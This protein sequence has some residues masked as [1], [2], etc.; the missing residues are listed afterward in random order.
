MYVLVVVSSEH[1]FVILQ[2]T[3]NPQPTS[4]CRHDRT[5]TKTDSETANLTLR[6]HSDLEESE[7]TSMILQLLFPLQLP[8]AFNP[9]DILH[10][11]KFQPNQ[12]APNYDS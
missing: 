9:S 6:P 12:K 8:E 4:L 7:D 10:T 3:I 1:S 2:L 11:I 5:R